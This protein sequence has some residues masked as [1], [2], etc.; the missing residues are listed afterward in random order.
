MCVWDLPTAG[1]MADWMGAFAL[2]SATEAIAS[3]CFLD[4]Q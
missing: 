1:W 4:L 3:R 2:L